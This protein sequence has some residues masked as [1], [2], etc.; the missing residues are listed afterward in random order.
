MHWFSSLFHVF[1]KRWRWWLIDC[2]C[3]QI[4]SV[5]TAQRG[6][7]RCSS[8]STVRDAASEH[9]GTSVLPN[10]ALKRFVSLWYFFIWEI[11]ALC[12]L[13]AVYEVSYSRNSRFNLLASHP[14]ALA[15]VVIVMSRLALCSRH[16]SHLLKKTESPRPCPSNWQVCVFMFI[17]VQAASIS[18]LIRSEKRKCHLCL[19]WHFSVQCTESSAQRSLDTHFHDNRTT[20][21]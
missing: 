8:N 13:Q 14:S 7:S 2:N 17:C 11:Y 12:R 6:V 3:N 20:H 4:P 10:W 9:P 21:L 15:S 19:W 18:F 16:G 1:K 5:C